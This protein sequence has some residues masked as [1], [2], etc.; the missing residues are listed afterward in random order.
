MGC[1]F[2]CY[3][4]VKIWSVLLFMAYQYEV[5]C[6]YLQDT[7]MDIMLYHYRQ[8]TAVFRTLTLLVICLLLLSAS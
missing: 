3:G 7:G 1:N 8:H 2:G 6:H 5:Y 4:S